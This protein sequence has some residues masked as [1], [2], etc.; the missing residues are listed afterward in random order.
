MRLSVSR[1]IVGAGLALLFSSASMAATVAVVPSNATP[2]VGDAF[3]VAV[4]GADFP[5]TAGA[6]LELRF[7]PTKVTVTSIVAGPLFTGGVVSGPTYDGTDLISLLGP[8]QGTLPSGS[9]LGMT[10]NF[11]ALAAGAANIELFDDQADLCWTDSVT[12]ACVPATYTQANVVIQHTP[13]I[14]VPAAAWLLVSALGGLAGVKR[15][16]RA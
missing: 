14:P 9:F 3:S 4:N 16:R 13:V 8:L 7:D 1:T 5:F 2:N 6:T 12:F 10:I 15:L 11:T